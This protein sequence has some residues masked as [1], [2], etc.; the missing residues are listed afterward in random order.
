MTPEQQTALE[1]V[2]ERPLSAD[3]IASIEPLLA[4]RN[5]VAIATILSV[6]RVKLTPTE[7]GVG[8]IL[9]TIGL[10]AGNL[11]LDA[12][13]A[14]TEFRHIKPLI[15]QGRLDIADPLPRAALDGLVGSIEGFTQAH[16]AALKA[17][18]E[19]PDPI[20]YNAVSDALN[21]AEGRLTLGS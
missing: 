4:D 17:L 8:R 6:G 18:A 9:A 7:I 11:L 21:I 3:E 15:E 2:A 5:D 14:I 19:Q 1:T 20:R 13:Y 16:A 10:T 12:L